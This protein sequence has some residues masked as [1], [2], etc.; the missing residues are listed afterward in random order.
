MADYHIIYL[1]LAVLQTFLKSFV[2]FALST[3]VSILYIITPLLVLPG[4]SRVYLQLIT[5]VY[6]CHFVENGIQGG[7]SMIS[8]RHAPA[9]SPSFPDAYTRPLSKWYFQKPHLKENLHPI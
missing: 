1:Q 3:T 6:M 4:M 7:I 2:Q 8:I 5:G 9:N